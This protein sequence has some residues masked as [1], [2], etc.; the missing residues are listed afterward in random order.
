MNKT[1]Q[2]VFLNNHSKLTVKILS[3]IYLFWLSITSVNGQGP[4]YPW[5]QGYYNGGN[6]SIH[7]VKLEGSITV[8]EGDVKYM[9]KDRAEIVKCTPC[10]GFYRIIIT[11][12]TNHR[13]GR[14]KNFTGV[15][16]MKTEVRRFFIIQNKTA[17]P[18]IKGEWTT[19]HCAE[20]VFL[21]CYDSSGYT[22][23]LVGT[24]GAM[25]FFTKNHNDSAKMQIVRVPIHNTVTLHGGVIT[26]HA[27]D[28]HT[29]GLL[30]LRAIELKCKNGFFDAAAKGYFPEAITWGTPSNGANGDKVYSGSAA[31]TMYKD[32]YSICP[33]TTGL[34]LV[35]GNF[36]LEG[37]PKVT[38]SVNGTSTLGS[39]VKYGITH[40]QPIFRPIMGEAGYFKTGHKAGKGAE[41]GGFGGTGGN[42]A[43]G[44]NGA[45]GSSGGNGGPG[46]LVGRGAR[47]G[48]IIMLRIENMIYETG[49]EYNTAGKKLF[50]INGE[51]GKYGG[52]GGTGG[53]GGLY[54]IGGT[55]SVV[56]TTVNW[57]GGNG[58]PGEPGDG[59]SGGDGSNGGNP[60]ALG[61]HLKFS[62]PNPSGLTSYQHMLSITSTSPGKAGTGGQAGFSGSSKS[63]SVTS[64]NFTLPLGYTFCTGGGGTTIPMQHICNCDSVFWALSSAAASSVSPGTPPAST[65]YTFADYDAYVKYDTGEVH[66]WSLH[67]G[68]N[69]T[70]HCYLYNDTQCMP[71]F[72]KMKTTLALP[73][74]WDRIDLQTY[75]A[76]RVSAS[77]LVIT[78]NQRYTPHRV[79]LQ[80]VATDGVLYDVME[81]GVPACYKG[82][83]DSK[84]PTNRAR[85]AADG[86]KND[87]GNPPITD[88]SI[89]EKNVGLFESWAEYVFMGGNTNKPNNKQGVLYGTD[90]KQNATDIAINIPNPIVQEVQYT[91]INT[92]GQ[93]LYSGTIADITNRT[94]PLQGLA[95]GV[96]NLLLITQNGNFVY[97]F[98][99]VN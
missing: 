49:H 61:L 6:L 22:I 54:G 66:L 82:S 29:G 92:L 84:Q 69:V 85:T 39:K 27:F 50:Y 32:I 88:E 26:C 19:G 42:S 41:G 55:G 94:V 93:T 10:G 23:G 12:N 44:N 71:M 80:W 56:G 13:H 53:D 97:K 57:S 1:V 15:D 18:N 30:P 48:G 11:N 5:M 73:S 16:S 52:N 7:N 74:N 9:D 89:D 96:Y 36:G 64:N 76:Q 4:S 14:F 62:Y 34:T 99:V 31:I 3:T 45:S 95:S 37:D 47:G 75:A 65:H 78:F 81:P 90:V 87:D 35:N 8:N 91:I 40:T 20:V 70:S 77:P 33:N 43:S 60:G 25:D 72:D 2:S 46:G 79:A 51:N 21:S 38:N 58:E 68:G 59:A 24:G 83:C 98:I 17:T 86:T 28:G 67:K 63:S